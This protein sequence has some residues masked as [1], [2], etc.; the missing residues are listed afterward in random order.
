MPK[1]F[2][3]PQFTCICK[4]LYIQNIQGTFSM[5]FYFEKGGRIG[6]NNM[7]LLIIIY[8]GEQKTNDF[9]SFINITCLFFLFHLIDWYT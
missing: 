5:F 8:F 9:Y 6:V 7:L 2:K 4:Y 3:N 1:P